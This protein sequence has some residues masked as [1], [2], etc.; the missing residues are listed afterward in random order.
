MSE[1]LVA[2]CVHPDPVVMPVLVLLAQNTGWRRSR[3]RRHG[4]KACGDS[5]SG[6]GG[7]GI[8]SAVFSGNKPFVSKDDEVATPLTIHTD[9][10][11]AQ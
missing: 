9:D 6:R 10:W 5:V 8:S 3:G 4:R 2:I 1:A 7:R 11:F